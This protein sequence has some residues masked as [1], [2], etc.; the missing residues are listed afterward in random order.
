MT[1]FWTYFENNSQ[2]RLELLVFELCF[3]DSNKL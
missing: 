3:G 2:K 1:D